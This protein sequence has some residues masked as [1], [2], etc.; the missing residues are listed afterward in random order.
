MDFLGSRPTPLRVFNVDLE[1]LQVPVPLYRMP[2][3]RQIT[4]MQEYGY[5]PRETVRVQT[6]NHLAKFLASCPAGQIT[7]LCIMLTS[8]QEIFRFL[9]AEVEPL[10]LNDLRITQSFFKLDA[11]TIPH[12]RH[13][14]RLDLL[15]TKDWRADSS[16]GMSSESSGD[17]ED[18]EDHMQ[19]FI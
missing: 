2:G 16:D 5:S 13:L 8:L 6:Y 15:P 17:R 9:T 11:F 10:R 3:L 18:A 7:K 1:H 14:T 4:F 19:G 12:L